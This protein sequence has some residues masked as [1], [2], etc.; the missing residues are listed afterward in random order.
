MLARGLYYLLFLVYLPWGKLIRYE[1]PGRKFTLPQGVHYLSYLLRIV[2]QGITY[3]RV[4]QPAHWAIG[5]I[6][7]TLATDFPQ[8]VRVV[9]DSTRTQQVMT[10]GLASSE[11]PEEGRID[12]LF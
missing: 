1:V 9:Y 2:I 11:F 6:G 4:K 10:V 8:H 3:R 5:R 12:D 7:M